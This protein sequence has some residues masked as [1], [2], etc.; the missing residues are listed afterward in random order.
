MTH[1]TPVVSVIMPI[2]NA[3]KFL[4]QSVGSV[5]NQS[6]KNFELICF[7]DNSSD[8]SLRILHKFREN[9][10]RVKVIDSQV[11][12]GPGGGVETVGWKS[13]RANL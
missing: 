5:L 9:D 10:N 1:P 11:N 3:E 2:Y 8:K 4:D 13:L 7:N 12:I 6:F